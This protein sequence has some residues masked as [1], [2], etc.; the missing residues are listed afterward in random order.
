MKATT[1]VW[2]AIRNIGDSQDKGDSFNATLSE[3]ILWMAT[4][5]REMSM[6]GRIVVGM[7]RTQEDALRGIDV[8]NA[9]RT[10]I[11]DDLKAMLDSVFIDMDELEEKPVIAE[12][13]LGTIV[14]RIAGDDYVA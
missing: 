8:K 6:A 7:G 5:L 1:N 4:K 10:A 11:G 12:A 2:I 13:Q 3:S 9:G 14:T